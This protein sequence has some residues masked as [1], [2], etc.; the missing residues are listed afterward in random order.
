MRGVGQS[1]IVPS[2]EEVVRLGA[3]SHSAV[4][5]ERARRGGLRSEAD[6]EVPS[7]M[8]DS[9]PSR[10]EVAITHDYLTQRGGAERVVLDL[11]AAFPN[12]LVYTS[13]YQPSA[14]FPEFEA[15]DI[16]PLILNRS[17]LL[18][19]HHRLAFPLLAPAFSA[20][21][22]HNPVVVC[23]S[24]GWAH[25][26]H[27]EGRKVVYCHTPA[28]WLYQTDRYLGDRHRWA[29]WPIEATAVP[30]LPG[31]APRT[32]PTATWSTPRW[33]VTVSLR[34]MGSRPSSCHHHRDL[35]SRA[36]SSP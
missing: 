29:R 18:R 12:S 16:A 23:S 8:T 32:R 14:T 28:R 27:V 9:A 6:R 22:L 36:R 15:L 31:P 33:C 26:V 5:C 13:L 2:G 24:S 19:R 17:A 1:V 21:H 25:G 10:H 30:T 7:L 20:L 11:A 35:R 34:S 4:G 3:G